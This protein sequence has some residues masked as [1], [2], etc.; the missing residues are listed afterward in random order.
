M[1]GYGKAL[2]NAFNNSLFASSCANRQLQHM[3]EP[4]PLDIDSAAPGHARFCCTFWK[5]HP[6]QI[7][8]LVTMH[9]STSLPPIADNDLLEC[10]QQYSHKFDFSRIGK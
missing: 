7:T 5:T 9:L 1:D 3:N 4:L 8:M 2:V 6:L 10:L